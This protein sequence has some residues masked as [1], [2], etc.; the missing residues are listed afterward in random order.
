M[1][2]I[3]IAILNFIWDITTIFNRAINGYYLDGFTTYKLGQAFS[4]FLIIFGLGLYILRSKPTNKPIW[5]KITTIVLYIL[6]SLILIGI[7]SPEIFISLQNSI[8]EFI[9]LIIWLI[10][11]NTGSS[12]KIKSENNTSDSSENDSTTELNLEDNLVELSK[13]NETNSIAPHKKVSKF[14]L[15]KLLLKILLTAA[16]ILYML[17]SLTFMNQGD[18]LTA[19]GV[20]LYIPCFLIIGIYYLILIWRNKSVSGAEIFLLPLLNK[21]NLFKSYHDN[22]DCKKELVKTVLPFLLSVFICPMLTSIIFI[23][24]YDRYHHKGSDALILVLL[25]PLIILAFS[26]IKQYAKNW[27]NQSN[28]IE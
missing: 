27:I 24:C 3:T 20:I 7:P 5:K 23:N 28:N 15:K 18:G 17:S 26:I 12:K 11:N 9:L 22:R 25:I 14:S 4:F 10:L 6:T 2:F 8:P 13:S 1:F 19:C 16:L 21:I